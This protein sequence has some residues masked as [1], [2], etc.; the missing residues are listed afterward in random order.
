MVHDDSY[1]KYR[2]DQPRRRERRRELLRTDRER[3]AAP[4]WVF[5]VHAIADNEAMTFAERLCMLAKL[6]ATSG[7]LRKLVRGV[8]VRKEPVSLALSPRWRGSMDG[9]RWVLDKNAILRTPLGG[10]CAQAIAATLLVDHRARQRWPEYEELR[11]VRLCAFMLPRA[12]WLRE[13][14][15]RGEGGKRARPQR[16][17]SLQLFVPRL[18]HASR[19]GMPCNK[20][21]ALTTEVEVFVTEELHETDGCETLMDQLVWLIERIGIVSAVHLAVGCAACA[22][23]LDAARGVEVLSRREDA[24]TGATRYSVRIQ[25]A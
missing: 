1:E 22:D 4:A 14:M 2:A 9:I 18:A 19:D 8:D 17:P 20:L 11:A 12:R 3:H 21:K 25:P 7:G 5:I 24:S 10:P 13:L 16:L 23:W 6:G 15:L